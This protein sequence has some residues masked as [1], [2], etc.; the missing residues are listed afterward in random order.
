MNV[1]GDVTPTVESEADLAAFFEAGSKPKSDWRIGTEHEKFAHTKSDLRPIPYDG[2]RGVGALLRGVQEEF[3]WQPVFERENLIALTQDG[4]AITLEPGGQIELSGAPLDS[5]HET[6]VEVYAHLGQLKAVA[7]PMGIGFIGAGFHPKWALA[8]IPQMPKARYGIM[9]GVMPTVG[10]HG[11]DMMYRTCT[12]QVNLDFS[13]EADMVRK[14]RVGLALQ[15]IATALFANS[16]FVE[17]KPNGFK[18]FRSYVWQH[19][20]PARTGILPFVFEDGFGFERY[21]DYALNVPMYFV[22]RDGGYVDAKGQTFREF[23]GGKLDAL[24]GQKPHLGDWETHLTTLFPD[25]RMKQFLEMRGA[26]GGPWSRICAL[27]ALWTGILY[28]GS[29]L[30][31]AWDLVKDW[32]AQ[33]CAALADEV[34]R[35]GLEAPAPPSSGMTSVAGLALSMLDISAAGL[36]ARNRIG[37]GGTDERTYLDGLGVIAE[38]GRSPASQ[39]LTKFN[40]P[41]NGSVDPL[42]TEDAY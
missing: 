8:D 1:L 36:S 23:L 2:A 26:D 22:V 37:P 29:A 6:C 10:K 28:D 3:G 39:L 30:D 11:L 12:V 13:S 41:W 20:D 33:D 27:S 25:V 15:P 18:S 5:I 31:A 21:V 4:Q 34:P 7:E 40:G 19:T 24:P 42:F 17:G 35:L 32:T 38:T 16:P 9:R 14:F